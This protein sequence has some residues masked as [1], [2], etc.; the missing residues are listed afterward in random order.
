MG[1]KIKQLDKP[2]VQYIRKRLEA[3]VEP[4]A[5]ELGV[6]IDLGSCTFQKSNCR[7]Q[8]KVVVLNLDGELVTEE[9]DA[10]KRSAKLFGFEPADLGKEFVV[11]GAALYHLRFEAEEP[12]VPAHSASRQR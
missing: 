5:E 12:Q 4:L 3:A 8:L 7:I 1:T 2:T 10:F 11:Q 9:A 6:A